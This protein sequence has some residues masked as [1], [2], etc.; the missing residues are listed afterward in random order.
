MVGAEKVLKGVR[1]WAMA[2]VMQKAGHLHQQVFAGVPES[3]AGAST[4]VFVSKKVA[5]P[6]GQFVDAQVVLK[7]G[8]GGAGEDEGRRAQLLDPPHP[9]EFLRADDFQGH[10][11]VQ[12]DIAVD[13]VTD[14]DFAGQF[15][16]VKFCQK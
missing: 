12:V 3:V 6:S 7:A 9:L 8:V 10:L 16:T 13:R 5:D 14:D 4:R 11:G 2:D 15:R 1:V